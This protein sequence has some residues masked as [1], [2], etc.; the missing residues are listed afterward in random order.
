MSKYTKEQLEKI[1]QGCKSYKEAGAKLGITKQAMFNL[2][3]QYKVN[4]TK[5]FWPVK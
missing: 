1:M 4:V 3:K 2:A 5:V